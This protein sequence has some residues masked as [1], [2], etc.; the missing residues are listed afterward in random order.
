MPEGR[1]DDAVVVLV[2][3]AFPA[4]VLHSLIGLPTCPA[5]FSFWRLLGG[6]WWLLDLLV[7][8]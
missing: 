8:C 5:A 4:I 1:C 7:H 2:D 6:F 3:R